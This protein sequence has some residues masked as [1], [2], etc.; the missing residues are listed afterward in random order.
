MACGLSGCSSGPSAQPP[1][2]EQNVTPPTA[3][4]KLPVNIDH[5]VVVIE[6]NHARQEIQ[7]NP[8]ALYMNELMKQGANF[9]NY[10]A[11]E[12]PSQPNYL[13]LFSGV[14]QDVTNDKVSQHQFS[15]ANLGSELQD[16][17]YT[18]VGFSEDLHYIPKLYR[19]IKD[20]EFSQIFSSLSNFSGRFFGMN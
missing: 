7:G 4:G 18:F 11:M 2:K 15:S 14:N 6:E 13:D 20:W 17:G 10:H 1:V 19:M 8:S 3:K 12:H 5:V 16:K 9:V